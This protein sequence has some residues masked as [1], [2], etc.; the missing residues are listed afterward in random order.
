MKKK[1]LFILAIMAIF[2]CIFAVSVSAAGSTS[3][4]YGEITV[5]DGE[6]EPSVID[7]NARVVIQANDGTYYTFPSYYVIADS[8]TFAWRKNDSLNAILGYSYS[9][10]SDIRGKII[11][12]ELPEGITALNPNNNGGATVFED[13]KIMVEIKLP[14][15]L[16]KIGDHTFNRC[17]KLATIDGFLEFLAKDTTTTLGHQMVAE[18]LWGDGVD[19]VI[20]ENVTSIP[21]RCFYGTKIK[22]VTF[23]DD[24]TFMGARSFQGCSNLTSVKLPSGVTELQ[25]H[26]FASCAKLASV[27]TSCAVNLEK[28]GNYCFEYAPL[29]SFDFTPFAANLTYLGEGL[30]NRCGS[31]STVTGYELADGITSVG[32]NMFNRCPLTTLT[33][34]KNITS[35]GSYAFF[36]HNSQQ[37]VLKIPNGVTTIGDHAFVRNNGSAKINGTVEIY[38]PASLTSFAGNYNFEYW[39]FDIM[40]IPAGVTIAQGVTNGTLDKGVVYYYTG[41]KDSLNINTTHN[42]ALLNAEWVSVDE[43]TGASNDKNYIVYGYNKCAAFYENNH[44]ESE[45]NVCVS[46]CQRCSLTIVDHQKDAESVEISYTSFDKDGIRITSCTSQ[47]CTHYVSETAGA[48]FTKKG[49][50]VPEYESVG[51]DIGFIVNHTAISDFEN[52]TG[53][54]INYGVFAVLKDNIGTNDIFDENGASRSGVIAADITD[55]EYDIFNLKIVGF[56]DEQKDVKLAMGA[57]VKATWD[58]VCEYSYLQDGTP[59]EG[60][61]YYFVSYNDKLAKSGKD[62]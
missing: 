8:A 31:L 38:L 33:F 44:N 39:D 49:T 35:I 22:S 42:S 3:D 29:T 20:P 23:H 52:I 14:S 32:A 13:A 51:L 5:I 48:L 41:A 9:N 30:F 4:A 19:L 25:S 60:Q 27:D 16:T 1:I 12:M 53:K 54:K 55:C 37:S 56:T 58:D 11:R 21:E 28:I 18:T 2:S 43:F 6:T 26:V 61:R 7:K 40:Y 34:P 24:V 50:S 10:A 45:L 15:T 59:T 46:T 62:E 17:Y 36:S 57:F 47:G